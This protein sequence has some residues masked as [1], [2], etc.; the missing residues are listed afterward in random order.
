MDVFTNLISSLPPKLAD[1]V[2]NNVLISLFSKGELLLHLMEHEED[3]KHFQLHDLLLRTGEI[4][5]LTIDDG[6]DR[7]YSL[8]HLNQGH[9]N[10]L[11]RLLKKRIISI[12]V[13]T[14]SHIFE[15]FE[16]LV[17]LSEYVVF[18][19][20]H[21]CNF[22]NMSKCVEY[23]KY[24]DEVKINARMWHEF[25]YFNKYP[26]QKKV[27]HIEM[28]KKFTYEEIIRIF[29]KSKKA[30]NEF[31][32]LIET[33]IVYSYGAFDFR[34]LSILNRVKQYLKQQKGFNYSLQTKLII[35]LGKEPF[36][37]DLLN[38][39]IDTKEITDLGINPISAKG[40]YK[41]PDARR[42]KNV[43]RIDYFLDNNDFDFSEFKKLRYI[44]TH[45]LEDFTKINKTLPKSLKE[46]VLRIRGDINKV[47]I[48][49]PPSVET[50]IIESNTEKD[51]TMRCFDLTKSQVNDIVLFKSFE[52]KFQNQDSNALFGQ[53]FGFLQ[54]TE[55]IK[56]FDYLPKSVKYFTIDTGIAK[57]TK[58]YE[59][60][61]TL[62]VNFF[63]VY[64]NIV[65][66]SE[67]GLLRPDL[68]NY[69]LSTGRCTNNISG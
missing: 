64:T 31:K 46:L 14:M 9:R 25:D 7:S 3:G 11:L 67:I 1:T 47:P 10:P 44:S 23:H 50:L 38:G 28:E 68:H 55:R 35:Y 56:R 18:D 33:F 22:E 15:N 12:K 13:L 21:G 53:L 37:F 27:I 19:N 5:E 8:I 26:N 60:E 30:N 36:S 34:E 17:E 2:K 57:T 24:I 4:P 48:K 52:G 54:P 42:F 16:Y 66:E 51:F 32:F 65:V 49:I 29:E 45:E 59:I 39:H 6:R 20:P 41:T 40:T 63:G 69:R 62:L 61:P 58:S 43:E